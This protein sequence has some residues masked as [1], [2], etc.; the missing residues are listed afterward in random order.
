ML[1][2]RGASACQ[3]GGTEG[4]STG[5]VGE[6]RLPVEVDR[7][8]QRH[9]IQQAKHVVGLHNGLL[10]RDG[11]GEEVDAY[12]D[13]GGACAADEGAEAAVLTESA[14]GVA[15]IAHAEDGEIHTLLGQLLPVRAGLI[16]Y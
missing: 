8:V 7:Q 6:Y 2:R 11:L 1:G 16:G 9:T 13:T 12:V 10:H 4:G 14:L 15:A 3:A 5:I